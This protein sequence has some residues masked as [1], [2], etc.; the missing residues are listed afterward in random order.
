LSGW[1]FDGSL[2]VGWS[3]VFLDFG[4]PVSVGV[5]GDSPPGEQQQQDLAGSQQQPF[6][7]TSAG[8]S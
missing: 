4:P 3:L 1:S 5:D 7:F 6:G 8:L 2:R